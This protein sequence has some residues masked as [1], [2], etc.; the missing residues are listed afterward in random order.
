MP[1][2]LGLILFGIEGI[3]KTSFALQFPKP[4]MIMPL[5]EPGY[6]SQRLSPVVLKFVKTRGEVRLLLRA[7]GEVK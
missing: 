2:G 3:G 1:R 6:I 7:M 5:K 4:L